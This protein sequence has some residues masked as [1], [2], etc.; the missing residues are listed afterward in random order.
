M[1][2]ELIERCRNWLDRLWAGEVPLISDA[3]WLPDPIDYDGDR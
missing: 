3:S 2:A 1:A